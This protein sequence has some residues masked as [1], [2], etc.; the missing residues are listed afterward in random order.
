VILDV[1]VH[2]LDVRMDHAQMNVSNSMDVLQIFQFNVQMEL[3]LQ[4]SQVVFAL[5][6][7]SI[8]V[9]MEIV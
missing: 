9:L 8:N 4:M 6:C 7:Q 1:W 2:C 3:A 5:E